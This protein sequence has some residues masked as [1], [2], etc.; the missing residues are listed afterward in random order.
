LGIGFLDEGRENLPDNRNEN[1]QFPPFHP[2]ILSELQVKQPKIKYEH[3]KYIGQAPVLCGAVP[4]SPK[5]EYDLMFRSIV[6]QYPEMNSLLELAQHRSAVCNPDTYR[7]SLKK[8]DVP[9]VQPLNE[10]MDLAYKYTKEM[11]SFL[12]DAKI[13]SIVDYDPTTGVGVPQNRINNPTTGQFF[14]NKGEYLNSEYGEEEMKQY[15]TDIFSAM[16]KIEFLPMED[17]KAGKSRTFFCGNTPLVIRQKMLYDRMDERMVNRVENWNK[18]WSRYGFTRQYGGFNRLAQAHLQVEKAAIKRGLEKWI[19]HIT[20]DVSGWDRGAP[21]MEQVYRLRKE[22]YGTMTDDEKKIHDYIVECIVEPFFSTFQGEIYQ[23]KTGNCSGS[24]KT[25]SDNTIMHIMME[26]YVWISL[27]YEKNGTLPT[28]LEII[29]Q[30]VNS[31]YGDDNLGSFILTDWVPEEVDDEEKEKYFSDKYRGY[32]QEFGLTI[33][34]SAYKIQNTLEGLEFLGGFLTLDKDTNTWIAKPRLSKVVT[35]LC[36]QLDGDRDLVQYSSIIQAISALTFKLEGAEWT[37]I[38]K[39]LR[40]LSTQIL[41]QDDGNTLSQNDISFLTSVALGKEDLTLQVMGFESKCFSNEQTDDR[42]FFHL[43]S[44]REEEGFKSDMNKTNSFI[45]LCYESNTNYKGQLFEF[46]AQNKFPQP[47]FEYTQR[48]LAHNPTIVCYA[49]WKSCNCVF[50]AHSKIDATQQCCHFIIEY[51]R[52][53]KHNRDNPQPRVISKRDDIIISPNTN[54]FE[55]GVKPA[56][57]DGFTPQVEGIHKEP[58]TA[59]HYS[60]V[61]QPYVKND[62]LSPDIEIL[63]TQ[64]R[65]YLKLEEDTRPCHPL[66][67]ML[68]DSDVITAARL[69]KCFKEG[70]FNPYGNGQQSQLHQMVITKPTYKLV[71]NVMTCF[72][73]CLL[74]SAVSISGTGE[75]ANDAFSDWLSQVVEYINT[76][77]PPTNPRIKELFNLLKLIDPKQLPNDY[78]LILEQ[79]EEKGL[80]KFF[81]KFK[82][83]SFNP[84]GNGQPHT[85]I[86]DRNIDD[87]EFEVGPDFHESVHSYNIPTWPDRVIFDGNIMELSNWLRI[88]EE[89]PLVFQFFEGSFNPYGNGQPGP[90]SKAAWIKINAQ[91]VGAMDQKT[92]DQAYSKYVKSKKPKQ[93]SKPKAPRAKPKMGKGRTETGYEERAIVKLSGC[94]EMYATALTYPFSWMDASG[95]KHVKINTDNLPCIPKFPAIKTRKS[96]YYVRGQFG[97]QNVNDVAFVAFAPWRLANDGI[98]TNNTDCPVL[99]ST[100]TA[101]FNTQGFPNLDDGTAWL[102]GAANFNTPYTKAQLINVDGVGI[103]FRVVGA[104]L[105]VKYVGNNLQMGGF[106][107]SYT[108]PNHGTVSNVLITVMSQFDTYTSYPII[109]TSKRNDG[110]TY[111]TFT[112]VSEDDFEFHPDLIANDL[113]PTDPYHN[114]FM[115]FV[116]TGL[117]VGESMSW[118]AILLTEETGQNVPDKTNTPADPSGVAI[119]TNSIKAET[120]KKINDN[121][122][123]KTLINGGASDMTTTGTTPA[124]PNFMT[125]MIQRAPE[126]LLSAM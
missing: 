123:V 30:I 14:R 58:S 17:I 76:W 10:R 1:S 75:N 69:A 56:L 86:G 61:F 55:F 34:E 70:S 111:L 66:H 81:S 112:P 100:T 44:K 21:L 94:A 91:R 52:K 41:T 64:M 122:P 7:I 45:P 4:K 102:S 117:P 8:C 103:K 99:F 9:R 105:R 31:L 65:E 118:E 27:F 114:H 121:V 126:V 68:M 25:T 73:T 12:I 38:R 3:M 20:A 43:Q 26:F 79:P 5:D 42:F 107:N 106:E 93:N 47:K 83:G 92:I 88:Y 108:D 29:Q 71:G 40:I 87:I 32:Y 11:L 33:K 39:Y 109:Y 96:K 19:R 95:F 50:E 2:K 46:N 101:P 53:I 89:N 90:I 78:R 49:Q 57:D 23:R 80:E 97:I 110:W 28:Y 98:T 74:P 18:C 6:E 16:S 13:S 119:A 48:G 36:F 51:L 84:Y 37:L 15:Y 22:L 63:I 113:W 104:G 35:T 67:Y 116:I 24:G 115:G 62:K 72:S 120:Q 60:R 125:E 59:H 82:E 124:K 54:Q 85:E 77:S